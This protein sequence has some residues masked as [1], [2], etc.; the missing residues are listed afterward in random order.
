MHNA[1]RHGCVFHFKLGALMA[2]GTLRRCPG[3]HGT[4]VQM[5]RKCS[6]G[7]LWL[8]VVDVVL[9]FVFFFFFL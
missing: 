2:E 7:V 3:Q 4:A 1:S 6:Q 9:F 8:F 5:E